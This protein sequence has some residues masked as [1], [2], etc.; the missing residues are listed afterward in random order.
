MAQGTVNYTI[1]AAGQTIA[2]QNTLTGDNAVSLNTTGTMPAG[3]AVTTYSTSTSIVV[4]AL[5]N[6]SGVTTTVSTSNTVNLYWGSGSCH[7][8]M[9]CTAST[10]TSLT[11][12]STSGAGTAIPASGTTGMVVA[13][14]TPYAVAF[15]GTSGK[16]FAALATYGG[17]LDLVDSST[18]SLVA[19]GILLGTNTA[20]CWDSSAGTT[21]PINGAVAKIFAASRTTTASALTFVALTDSSI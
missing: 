4:L 16:L 21:T 1:A 14:Q 9:T 15:D 8:G 7:Y 12:S 6:P 2:T 20:W 13:K 18:A 10:S 11:L 17:H 5:S 3:L 19:N